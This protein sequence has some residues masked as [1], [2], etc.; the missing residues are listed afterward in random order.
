MT[1]AGYSDLEEVTER[2]RPARHVGQAALVEGRQE[3]L[4]GFSEDGRQPA[5]F[6][7]AAGGAVDQRTVAFGVPDDLADGDLARWPGQLQSAMATPDGHDKTVISKVLDDLH[8]VV[9]GDPMRVGDLADR[10]QPTV[11][12]SKVDQRL[13]RIVGYFLV[14][15]SPR[16][17]E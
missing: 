9:L 2:V 6:G 17:D 16:P 4:S 13:R 15:V 7:N 8:Q 1:S 10:C 5:P 3:G 14:D 12:R 11:I